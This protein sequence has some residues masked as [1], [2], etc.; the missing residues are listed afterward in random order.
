MLKRGRFI[1]K[2]DHK[3]PETRV[4]GFRFP[5]EGFVTTLRLPVSGSVYQGR[6]DGTIS[7]FRFPGGSFSLRVEMRLEFPVSSFRSGVLESA[8]N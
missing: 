8:E 1:D 3:F 4:S 6:S 2:W 5:A 7:D